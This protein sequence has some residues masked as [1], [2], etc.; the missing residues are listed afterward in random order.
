MR[1]TRDISRSRS[2]GRSRGEQFT[3]DNLTFY[4]RNPRTDIETFG[5]GYPEI[6]IAI[7]LIRGYRT[8]R[9]EHRHLRSQRIANGI[10]TISGGAITNVNSVW[11]TA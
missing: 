7:R 11:S 4:V 6:E 10:L 9:H 1:A 2:I 5:Y 3:R 8:P